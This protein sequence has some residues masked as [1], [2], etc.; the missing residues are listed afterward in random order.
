MTLDHLTGFFCGACL[1]VTAYSLIAGVAT[2]R[3]IKRTRAS[4]SKHQARKQ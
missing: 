4:I 2:L 3:S 1:A